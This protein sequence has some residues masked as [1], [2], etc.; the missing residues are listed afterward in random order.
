MIR[1]SRIIWQ[2][3]S[4]A[5]NFAKA[6][7]S[8]VCSSSPADNP[9]PPLNPLAQTALASRGYIESASGRIDAFNDFTC[10]DRYVIA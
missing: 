10:P 4:T 6:R 8:C 7:L 2:R 1:A 5:V 9:C 3:H